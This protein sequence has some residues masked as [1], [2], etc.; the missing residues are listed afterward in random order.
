MDYQVVNQNEWLYSD[1]VVSKLGVKEVQLHTAKA[2]YISTQILLNHLEVGTTYQWSCQMPIGISLEV[3]KQIDVLCEKNTGPISF[4][5]DEEKGES[6]DGY[7]TRKAPFRVNDA[8]QP[9]VPGELQV[10]SPT[11]AL[12][13]AFYIDECVS[14]SEHVL[15]LEL[16][17]GENG[18]LIPITIKVFNVSIPKEKNL[19]ISNWF[20]VDNMA[21]QH[22]LE[23]WSEEHW[24]MIDQYA[25][26]MARTRQTHFWIPNEIR[27]VSRLEGGTYEFKFDRT[28]R[29]IE[30]FLSKGFTHIEGNLLYVRNDFW[31]SHFVV[32]IMGNRVPANS[33]EGYD[34]V[35]QYLKAW[36]TFLEENHWLE[37]LH[38]HVGD[39]PIDN[40][41]DEYRILS[42]IVRKHLPG[43]P[44]MEAVETYDLD[45]AVDIWIPKNNYF[46]ENMEKFDRV[47]KNGDELWFYT[48]CFPGGHYVNRLWDMPLIRTRLLHWGNYRYDLKGY[49]H[50]GF[51]WCEDADP[52]NHENLFFPPGDTHISY[53]G[54]NIPWGSMRLEAMRA[55]VQDYE[56]LNMLAK[57]DKVLADEL[58]KSCLE[59]F[60]KPNEDTTHFEEVRL[61]ILMALE[62]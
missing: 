57:K 44:L 43:V 48:C 5:V 10:K 36:K 62:K 60:D 7:T 18:A 6:A 42:G 9:I 56:L 24:A 51:N 40:C 39:E 12:Y 16:T 33:P 17:V 55:G 58:C 20:R 50:W 29:L 38:Q 34:F 52:F 45:G 23:M 13:L 19:Y 1:S 31:D 2:A 30:M 4:C 3:Y 53:P 11:E 21:T 27:E 59:S 22:D 46:N 15:N 49:L 47:R 37:L 28:K 54:G 8:L 26:L 35:S 61:K 25:D 41:K 14:A 32:D